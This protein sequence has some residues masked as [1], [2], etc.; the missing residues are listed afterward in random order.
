VAFPVLAL[1]EI[2]VELQ[3]PLST[4]RL[5]HLPLDD[6]CQQLERNLF[7]LLEDADCGR[8]KDEG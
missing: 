2:G 7:A 5:N 8:M 3:Y 1:D 6:I 4:D